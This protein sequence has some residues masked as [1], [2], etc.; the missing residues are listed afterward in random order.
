MGHA[1]RESWG[2]GGPPR[3]GRQTLVTPAPPA[4]AIA[5][6]I[7]RRY[8]SAGLYGQPRAGSGRAPGAGAAYQRKAALNATRVDHMIETVYD[9][10]HSVAS[11]GRRSG[12]AASSTRGGGLLTQGS[13]FGSRACVGCQIVTHAS[14]C[15]CVW[16]R[17]CVRARG[18]GGSRN[19]HRVPFSRFSRCGDRTARTAR[20]ASNASASLA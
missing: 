6:Y 4:Q 9:G 18:W 20:A 1:K 14:V 7:A 5:R 17:P 12:T 10:W 15:V 19:V 3:E 11:W 13:L 16:S 2:G 8:P